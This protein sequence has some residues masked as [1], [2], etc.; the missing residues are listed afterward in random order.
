MNLSQIE[1]IVEIA[2]AGSISKAAQNMY[3]SQPGVSKALHRFEDEVGAKI[4]ERVNTGIR[5]TPIGRVFVESAQDI[6]EQA[7]RL[8]SVFADR[9]VA[10]GLE[11]SLA[12]MSYRFMQN[13]ISEIYL[14]YSHNP[15]SIKYM[16]CGFDQITDLIDKGDVEIGVVTF[17]QQDIKMVRKKAA[18]KS[19]EY[20]GLGMAVPYIGVSKQ[21]K[22]YPESVTGFELQR[23]AAMPIVSISP[24][25][26]MK[27]T[28]WDFMRHVF[29][30]GLFKNSCREI[31]TNNTGTMREIVNSTDGFTLILLNNG[32]Y[33]KYGF[34]DDIRLIPLD[35]EGMNFEMAWL[36]RANTARSPLADEFIRTLSRYTSAV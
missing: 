5:L 15:I 10:F 26:P 12:S 17:W 22:S 33:E 3:I 30:E 16:E 29:G 2:K 18:A 28:G 23:L 25:S 21:S 35:G 4:F 24:S 1:V 7:E 11:L 34:Y 14:K 20:H 19:L 36:Q 31:R 32:L 9:G 27:G 8:G 13:I 6:V